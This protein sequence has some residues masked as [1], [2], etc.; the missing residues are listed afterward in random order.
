MH[1]I[2]A[3][4]YQHVL[5]PQEIKLFCEVIIILQRFGVDDAVVHDGTDVSVCNITTVGVDDAVVLLGT[6]VKVTLC[7]SVVVVG[8]DEAVV[9]VGITVCVH[10]SPSVTVGTTAVVVQLGIVTSVT[11]ILT[12]GILLAVAHV[13]MVV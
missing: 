5:F 8:M 13:G 6:V 3:A 11:A 4:D 12:V 2:A 10:P 1:N 9:H 7:D